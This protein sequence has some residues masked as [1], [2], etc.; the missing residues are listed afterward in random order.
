MQHSHTIQSKVLSFPVCNLYFRQIELRWALSRVPTLL[1]LIRLWGIGWWGWCSR[2]RVTWP[3]WVSCLEILIK[4]SLIECTT[5]LAWVSQEMNPQRR[6]QN[7][8]HAHSHSCLLV[9]LSGPLFGIQLSSYNMFSHS[10]THYLNK[11]SLCSMMCSLVKNSI[12]RKLIEL[13]TCSA[14]FGFKYNLCHPFDSRW[15]NDW[16]ALSKKTRLV[17]S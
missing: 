1:L 6:K 7:L 14:P 3:T 10:N 4:K 17:M 9:K 13:K 12:V 15:M 16:L 2:R 11:W 8:F 5:R